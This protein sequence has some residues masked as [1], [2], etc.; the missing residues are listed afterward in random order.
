MKEKIIN[1][2]LNLIK[3]KSLVTFATVAIFMHL[4]ITE[5]LEETTSTAIILLVFQH[6]FDKEKTVRKE[7][8]QKNE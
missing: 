3:I 1:S 8:G 7:E 2:I 5:R 4:V 6:L